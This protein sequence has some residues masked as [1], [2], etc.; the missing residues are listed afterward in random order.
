MRTVYSVALS[1][2]CTDDYVARCS[3]CILRQRNIV[4]RST[5][6]RYHL[7]DITTRPND[8]KTIVWKNIFANHVTGVTSTSRG[9]AV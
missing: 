5:T 8:D 7:R 2:R 1:A 3:P 9:M 4:Y 6:K